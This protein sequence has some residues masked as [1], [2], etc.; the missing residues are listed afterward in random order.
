MGLATPRLALYVGDRLPSLIL[1][2]SRAQDEPECALLVQHAW[3]MTSVD[4]SGPLVH[5]FGFDLWHW[6]R[7]S[8]AI[9][10]PADTSQILGARVDGKWLDR[11]ELQ[12]T[13]LGKR[14]D[15]PI[16]AGPRGCRLEVIYTTIGADG[17]DAW[18]RSC[19]APVPALPFPL[20]GCKCLWRVASGLTPLHDNEMRLYNLPGS[21]GEAAHLLNKVKHAWHL[22]DELLD[23]LWPQL[24]D[25]A[26]QGGSKRSLRRIVLATA[27]RRRAT[28]VWG[29][30]S[31]S[32]S[33]TTGKTRRFW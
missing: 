6:P 8:L 7:P 33:S 16:T 11:L 5:H 24:T 19:A 28:F 25:T 9:G 13:T 27:S 18:T 17:A 3:L 29:K 22:P 31:I 4:R 2:A 26:A 1:Q 23:R 14:L 32:Y 30:H 21:S 20:L 15:V 12:T 10:L